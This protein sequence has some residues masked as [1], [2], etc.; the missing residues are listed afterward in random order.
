M[1]IL[2]CFVLLATVSSTFTASGDTDENKILLVPGSGHSSGEIPMDEFMCDSCNRRNSTNCQIETYKGCKCDAL[3]EAYGDCCV[4]APKCQPSTA[5]GHTTNLLLTTLE[6]KTL[7]HTTFST[8]DQETYWMVAQCPETQLQRLATDSQVIINQCITGSVAPVTD[9]LTGII[10]KNEFCAMCHAVSSESIVKWSLSYS[11]D[12]R[13]KLLLNEGSVDVI[14]FLASCRPCQYIIPSSVHNSSSNLLP[15]RSCVV[16]TSTCPSHKRY[17]LDA[18]KNNLLNE[19]SLEEF[20]NASYHCTRAAYDPVFA[21]TV[22]GDV[23]GSTIYRNFHCSLCDGTAIP[24]SRQCALFTDF[25][26]CLLSNLQQSTNRFER[27]RPTFNLLLDINRDGATTLTTTDTVTSATQLLTT[28]RESEVFDPALNQCRPVICPPKYIAR[29]GR[30]VPSLLSDS[31]EDV[32]KIAPNRTRIASDTG[33]RLLEDEDDHPTTDITDSATLASTAPTCDFITLIK[34]RD[35]Y[36]SLGNGSVIFED[37]AF[38]VIA[39]DD[40]NNPVICVT[41]NASSNTSLA[42]RRSQHLKVQQTIT[43]LFTVP[44]LIVTLLV[45]VLQIFLRKL[46]SLYG[47]VIINLGLALFLSDSLLWSAL[48]SKASLSVVYFLL[49]VSSLAVACWLCVI[50]AVHIYLSLRKKIQYLRVREL[51]FGQKVTLG[52]LYV[53]FGWGAPLLIATINNEIYGQW[54]PCLSGLC[55]PVNSSISFVMVPILAALATCMLI[56]VSIFIKILKLSHSLPDKRIF[57]QFYIFLVLVST[58]AIG[59]TFDFIHLLSP[60]HLSST[61]GFYAFFVVKFIGVLLFF[62]GL[63]FTNK[64]RET[65]CKSFSRQKK[66]VHPLSQTQQKE[67]TVEQAI[68]SMDA[69]E[70]TQD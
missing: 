34:G 33:V 36:T 44:S 11:C 63:V 3:C 49:Q 26:L 6:C 12:D 31:G 13:F 56:S 46:Y 65:I 25:N 58:F 16:H 66:R 2:C 8:V 60:S 64:L 20:E 30:C 59:W 70:K 69:S 15:P 27:P 42:S 57:H 50:L 54:V 35:M 48:K 21:S 23:Y 4:D 53:T 39:F 55:I 17:A 67:S 29:M 62:F 9:K 1:A 45:I 22:S 24:D 18:G 51:K 68:S 38:V 52:C 7:Y 47:F 61:I 5:S 10:Y 19:L 43:S 32:K 28:C 37:T 14:T 40:F 41:L